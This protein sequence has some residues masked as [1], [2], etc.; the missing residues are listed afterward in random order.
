MHND[1]EQTKQQDPWSSIVDLMSALVLVLFLAV[2]FFITNYSEVTQR[3]DEEHQNL[4]I[5]TD[6]LK[7]S[8]TKFSNLNQAYSD[9][10]QKEYLLTTERDQLQQDKIL[11]QQQRSQPPHENKDDVCA[12]VRRR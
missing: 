8:E 4:L 10:K 2:I 1:I 12:M 6:K 11:L 5:Q 7:K 3:L 9:L